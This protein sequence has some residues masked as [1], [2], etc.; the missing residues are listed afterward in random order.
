M[1]SLMSC[2]VLIVDDEATFRRHATRLLAIRGFRV[3]GEAGDAREALRA[4]RELEPGA[5]LLDVNLPDRSGVELARDLS[6]LPASPRVLLT[7]A[8]ADI[9]AEEVDRCG[10]IG[11]VPKAQL[12]VSDLVGLLAPG[13]EV[14]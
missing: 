8:D 4:A 9:E 13:G 11:F 2:S 1:I 6:G 10:A 5:V 3:V 12:P 7:S 14:V